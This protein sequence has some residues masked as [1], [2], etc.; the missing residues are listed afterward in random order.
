[1]QQKAFNGEFN[2][3]EVKKKMELCHKTHN[4]KY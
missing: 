1:M 3:I 4:V 2:S